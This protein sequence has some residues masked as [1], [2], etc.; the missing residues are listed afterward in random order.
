M[1]LPPEH[2]A[3]VLCFITIGFL[4]GP[5]TYFAF[6]QIPDPGSDFLRGGFTE[7]PRCPLAAA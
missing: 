7:P 5:T 2:T 6:T 3:S 4:A 1:L